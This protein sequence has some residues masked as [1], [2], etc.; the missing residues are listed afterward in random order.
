VVEEVIHFPD[1]QV[2]TRPAGDRQVGGLPGPALGPEGER[3]M[4]PRWTATG[5]QPDHR[6]G[7]VAPESLAAGPSGQ[8]PITVGAIIDES[9]LDLWQ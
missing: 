5:R 8:G 1:R 2:T 6:G 9:V 7:L 3:R 4:Q